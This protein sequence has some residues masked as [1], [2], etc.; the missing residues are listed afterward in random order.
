MK[1]NK[2][3]KIVLI[4]FV[5]LNI[6]LLLFGLILRDIRYGKL[7]KVI[8]KTITS[9]DYIQFIT[10]GQARTYDEELNFLSEGSESKTSDEYRDEFHSAFFNK[11]T[12]IYDLQEVLGYFGSSGIDF[13][14]NN[15]KSFI[16]LY[17]FENSSFNISLINGYEIGL[18]P[19]N[20]KIDVNVHSK[21]GLEND[22]SI[23]IVIYKIKILGG[24]EEIIF[25]D[26]IYD[27]IN[28]LYE[29]EEGFLNSVIEIIDMILNQYFNGIDLFSLN[30][31]IHNLFLF[32][33]VDIF[34]YSE[35][36]TANGNY[37]DIS[38]GMSIEEENDI[39]NM[40]SLEI[41][42]LN[43]TLGVSIQLKDRGNETIP[44]STSS[45]LRRYDGNELYIWNNFIQEISTLGDDQFYSTI[46]V[47][48]DD[49]VIKI[50][51]IV[52]YN[53]YDN[54]IKNEKKQTLRSNWEN[55][56]YYEYLNLDYSKYFNQ[57]LIDFGIDEFRL[58]NYYST[59]EINATFSE[60]F[61]SINSDVTDILWK[62][63]DNKTSFSNFVLIQNLFRPF[64]SKNNI[65]NYLK[66]ISKE[67]VS[68]VKFS[69][70]QKPNK[71]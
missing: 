39:L 15:P 34:D 66:N 11:F 26:S 55:F 35:K 60:E 33:G 28:Y 6:F 43:K 17:Q 61:Q 48:Y 25:D 58:T 51:P 42:K 37:I 12:S 10:D 68:N 27:L 53:I 59:S 52:Q 46:N 40:S 4:V 70:L 8:Y 32:N 62:K 71:I 31:D 23:N 54:N 7:E 41:E 36:F 18:G 50:V 3:L 29:N 45:F 47:I 13:L 2:K 57:A 19:L 21:Y 44:F 1:N 38:D 20:Y 49:D 14:I 65:D 5:F 64:L 67:M 16:K 22:L 69:D 30:N 63:G 56:M 9:D 24:G